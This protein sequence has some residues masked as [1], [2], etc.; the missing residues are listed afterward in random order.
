MGYRDRYRGSQRWGDS[1]EMRQ[2]WGERKR[3]SK[4]TG[5][6]SKWWEEMVRDLEAII[7][8]DN[9]KRKRIGGRKEV[10][11]A[12][13]KGGDPDGSG[14]PCTTFSGTSPSEDSSITTHVSEQDT[15]V[16]RG[17]TDL[18]ED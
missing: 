15:E 3:G 11:E 8:D 5:Q 16:L 10:I 17:H 6:E 2:W 14:C 13:R 18:C 1:T 4:T 7:S 9:R 12:G